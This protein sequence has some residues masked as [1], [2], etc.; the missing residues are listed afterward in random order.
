MPRAAGACACAHVAPTLRRRLAPRRSN[1]AFCGLEGRLPAEF[2][3]LEH[4]ETLDLQGNQLS[5]SVPAA[6]TAVGAFPVLATLQLGARC[7]GGV[8]LGAAAGRRNVAL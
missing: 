5:G 2:A 6:W 4:L 1:L 8:R 3:K 7:S